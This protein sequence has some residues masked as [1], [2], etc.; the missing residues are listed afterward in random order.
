M[1]EAL[2]A[3]ATALEL[4]DTEQV[5][6]AEFEECLRHLAAIN[7]WTGAYRPTLRWLDRLVRERGATAAAAPLT[8][9]DVGFGYGDML[10][11]IAAWAR[12]RGVAVRLIGV[13]LNPWSAEA[14]ARATP[15]GL[16]IRWEVGDVFG[17]QPQEPVDVVISALFTHHLP[18]PDLVRFLRWMSRRAR[19]GWFVNDLHRHPLSYHTVRAAARLLPVNRMVRHDAPLSVA[20]AFTRDDWRRLLAEAELPPGRL[21][22]E[23][24]FPFRYGVGWRR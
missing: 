5:P 1:A 22:V 21:T 17:W 13:D 12:R 24:R 19:C 11:R 23:W 14:A 6:F 15:A 7:R 16:P 8:V 20:R 4:M 9:L 3:R 18:D 10:R 2:A